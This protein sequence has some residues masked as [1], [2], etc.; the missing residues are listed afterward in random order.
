MQEQ[1]IIDLP[2]GTLIGTSSDNYQYNGC[3]YN[4]SY[5]LYADGLGGITRIQTSSAVACG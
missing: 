1:Q 5:N 3:D 2:I 4:I